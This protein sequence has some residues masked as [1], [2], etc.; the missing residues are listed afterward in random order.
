M[1]QAE[2]FIDGVAMLMDWR[3][4]LFIFLGIA[5][6]IIMGSIPG[7]SA[8]LAIGL[9]LAPSMFMSPIEAIVFLSSVY[10]SAVY[11]GGITAATFNIPGAPGAVATTFDGYP[12]T[13]EG[14]GN[15]V[16][17]ISLISS[18]L[19]VLISYLVI[20]FFMEPLGRFVLQFGP[21]ELLMI[22]LIALSII[23]L[24]EGTFLKSL[25]A[26][27]FGL[28]IGTIGA[29]PLGAPRGTFG[30]HQLY[31]GIPLVP[32]VIGLFAISELFYIIRQKTL[33]SNPHSDLPSAKGAIHYLKEIVSG[34]REGL[35]HA[36]VTL[37]SGII[38]VSIGLLPAAGSSIA[39]L[40]SYSQIKES[41]KDSSKFGK[42]D[43]RGVVASETANNA[44]EAGA[45]ATTL[46][47]GIPGGGAAAVL[48]SAFLMHGMIPGP[49]LV[50]DS[51]DIVY[52][53]ILS[54]F[55]QAIVLLFVGIIFIYYFARVVYVP[56]R[57]LIPAI[58]IMTV[59][60]TY[61]VIGSMS[62]PIIALVLGVLGYV[63]R[64]LN[65]P[66][67]SVVLGL[68][69]GSMVESEF[70]KMYRMYSGNWGDVF[71]R[72]IFIV[73]L[74]SVIAIW[75]YILIKKVKGDRNNASA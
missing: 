57:L 70:F 21:P 6:G 56:L 7:I 75:V 46:A 41:V 43:S 19:G 45:M 64:Q 50:R 38:G 25:L 9:M 24:V 23:G 16:L 49:Y 54:N 65:Y 40:I 66:I 18:L 32:A 31:D 22:V 30:F 34:I 4:F 69:L 1:I 74:V 44:S 67:V 14:K 55:L 3:I 28:L 52:A 10:T 62:Y 33:V 35:R 13:K 8:T 27:V 37:K 58:V 42:G 53:F 51:M 2:A 59:I 11:A 5:Y 15:Y 36:Y 47:F 73:L 61:S 60:G 48:L 63:L 29:G 71:T 39:S 68:I 20:L 26:G 17:G 12:L 72:P